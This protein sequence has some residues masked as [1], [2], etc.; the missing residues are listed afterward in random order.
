MNR[1]ERILLIVL[2]VIAVGAAGF[3]L[4]TSLGGEEE[5]A[6]PTPVASAPPIPATPGT[7]AGEAPAEPPRVFRFFGGRDPF[8]PLIV[9]EAGAGGV[10]TAPAETEDGEAAVEPA[11]EGAEQD[12]APGQSVTMGGKTV[13][14]ID[15]IDE[16]TVQVEVDGRTF[17][18][19][20]GEEFAQN[21]EVASV[22]GN[23]ARFLFGDESFTLCEGGAPK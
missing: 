23:C 12:Q 13:T 21:F 14:L 19:D 15:V 2:G 16:N 4:V 8:V 17:T 20:E 3:F 6:A 10:G 18:V 7:E 5:Q 22:S 1:R 9:A 11:P